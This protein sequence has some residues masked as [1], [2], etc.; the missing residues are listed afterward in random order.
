MTDEF[1]LS[2]TIILNDTYCITII[3]SLRFK[4]V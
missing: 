2:Y 4:T 1:I 3:D